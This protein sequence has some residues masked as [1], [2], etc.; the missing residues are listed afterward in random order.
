MNH[1]NNPAPTNYQILSKINPRAN[2]PWASVLD[3]HDLHSDTQK[4]TVKNAATAATMWCRGVFRFDLP[5]SLDV[6]CTY[7]AVVIAPT[8]KVFLKTDSKKAPACPP[9][10][11]EGDDTRSRVAAASSTSI[12]PRFSNT[13]ALEGDHKSM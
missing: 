5:S 7:S 6:Y 3:T 12:H 9:G 13:F 2:L 1:A 11:E 4:K 8:L 10:G